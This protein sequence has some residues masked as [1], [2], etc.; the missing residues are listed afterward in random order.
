M[1]LYPPV[2]FFFPAVQS[3][4]MLFAPDIVIYRQ[5]TLMMVGFIYS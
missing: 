4:K 2:L 3:R 5:A 1:F